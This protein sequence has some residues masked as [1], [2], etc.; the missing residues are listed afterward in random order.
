MR[1]W[2]RD[3]RVAIELADAPAG[4]LTVKRSGVYRNSG[5]DRAF[6]GK[7]PRPFPIEYR[8]PSDLAKAR[9]W[10]EQA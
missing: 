5:L 6:A 2:N 1:G 3:A 10:M 4:A 8:P 7:G 9:A